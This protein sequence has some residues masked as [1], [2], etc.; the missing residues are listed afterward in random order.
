M[1]LHNCQGFGHVKRECPSSRKSEKT[2]MNATLAIEESS[3]EILSVRSA[4]EDSENNIDFVAR[5]NER[6]DQ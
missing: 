4:Y 5:V 1:R 6:S 2:A 3:L